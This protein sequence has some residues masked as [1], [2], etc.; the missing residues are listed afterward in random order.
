MNECIECGAKFKGGQTECA[1]CGAAVYDADERLLTELTAMARKFNEALARGNKLEFEK[2]L[3]DDFEG[4]LTDAEI[5]TVSDK[6]SLLETV[7]FDKNFVSYNL[8]DAELIERTTETATVRCIQTVTRRSYFEE[9]KFEPYI[10]RGTIEFVR[11]NGQW[12]IISQNT[13]TI[14]ENGKEFE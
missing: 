4:C 6:K 1:Y 10:E 8:H 14:D 2:Y 11:E 12:R 9:G 3:A 13:V 7:Q 5:E